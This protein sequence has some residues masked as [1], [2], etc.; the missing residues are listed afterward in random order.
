MTDTITEPAPGAPEPAAPPATPE[1]APQPA[2]PAEPEPQP[3][4]A[5]ADSVDDLPPWAQKLL[6]DTRNEAA[7]HRTTA[8]DLETKLSAFEQ[9]HKQQL[10]GIAKALG[11]EPDEATPEQ[12][13]AERD[14]EKARADEERSRARQAAVEL[15]TYRAAATLGAD[16]NALLDSRS[17]VH[18]IEGLDPGADDF[19]EQ[20]KDAITAALDTHPEW[21]AAP[22]PTPE[23]PPTAP[24]PR[25]EPTIARAN[26]QFTGAPQQPRQWTDDD[27]ARA[28]PQQVV[29]AMQQGLL[30]ELGA[31]PRG[32]RDRRVN[33]R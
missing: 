24:P 15:A 9:T 20:V 6:R 5:H 14:A 8:K 31:G 4:P 26:G 33:A 11:L 21:K 32:G 17:F 2:Q 12:I 18:A 27:V 3:E 7:K 22:S 13:A 23:P 1:P 10:S 30:H 19:A 25:P 28:S 29:E 16:G